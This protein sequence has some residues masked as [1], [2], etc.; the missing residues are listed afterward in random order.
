MQQ[1]LKNARTI[2]SRDDLKRS[3]ESLAGQVKLIPSAC[4]WNADEML[5]G[6]LQKTSP[7]EVNV[8]INTKPGAVTVPKGRDDS[9]ATLLIPI[10]AIGDSPSPFFITSS[11]HPR[12]RWRQPRN[13]VKAMIT[14]FVQPQRRSSQRFSSSTGWRQYSCRALRN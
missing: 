5:I 10:S 11:K 6:Y 12:K 3:F 13:Y 8:A 9:R 7:L 2:F 14:Q 1:C 4:I